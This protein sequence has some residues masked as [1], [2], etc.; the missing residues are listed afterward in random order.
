MLESLGL[1]GLTITRLL[2]SLDGALAS[3][4]L[5]TAFALMMYVLTHN[6]YSEV[7]RAF[8]AL[9]AFVTVV[10]VGD[11]AVINSVGR[12]ASAFW[13]RFQWLGIAF[14]PAAYLQL[15]LALLRSVN[16]KAP[17]GTATVAAGY[18]I[19]LGLLGLTLFTD[20]LVQDGV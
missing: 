7:G 3:A 20:L 4:V 13:L 2:V 9:M 17:G 8:T 19:G 14:V 5:L 11:V 12:E 10:Y 15:S 1:A 18:A 16:R 6:A